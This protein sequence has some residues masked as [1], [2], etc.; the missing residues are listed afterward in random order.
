MQEKFVFSILS[1]FFSNIIYLFSFYLLFQKLNATYLGI[2]GFVNSVINL[3]F[4][5]TNIGIDVIHYQYSGYQDNSKFFTTFLIIKISILNLNLILTI[6]IISYLKLWNN[7]FIYLILLILFSKVINEI[8]SIFL[9]NLRSRIKVF[10]VEISSF[11]IIIGKSLVIIYV[12]FNFIHSLITLNFI[13]LYNFI[14][15]LIFFILIQIL[16]KQEIQLNK[17]NR[18]LIYKYLR[19]VSPFLIFSV[20]SIISANLGSIIISYSLGYKSLGYISFVNSYLIPILLTI[21]NSIITIYLPLFSKFYE[22]HN[23][24]IIKKIIYKLEKYFSIFFLSIIILIILNG[25]LIFSILIP[26]YINSVP[27]LKIMIFFPYFLSISQP[28]S[29]YFVAAKKQKIQVFINS[30]TR[31]L[32]IILL[33]LLI[34]PYGTFGYSISQTIPWILWCFLNYYFSK[35]IFKLNF[36]KGILLQLIFAIIS[37]ILSY[38]LKMI[39]I[40]FLNSISIL[41]LTSFLSIGLY[42]ILLINFKELKK[43]DIKFLKKIFKLEKYIKSLRNEFNK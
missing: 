36:Q 43:D 5:F 19:D 26:N 12:Y 28:R 37:I 27:I 4:I 16:S 9:V 8:N 15:D 30:I 13:A 21:P 33:V 3:G 32:I 40:T 7:S 41:L 17:I 11:L 24:R 31:S 10:K 39:F 23:L 42:F 1:Q 34:K 14:F 29:Y 18:K 25:D 38:L 2:W 35:K 22:K 20:I 6:I